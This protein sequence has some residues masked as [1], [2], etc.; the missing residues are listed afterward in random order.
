MKPFNN[1]V[2][3]DKNNNNNRWNNDDNRN[4]L[5]NV[6]MGLSQYYQEKVNK[7]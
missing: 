6:Y 4:Q 3:N 5:L 7:Y 1:L 2:N